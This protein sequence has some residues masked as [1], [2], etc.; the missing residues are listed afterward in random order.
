MPELAVSV[1]NQ[2]SGQTTEPTTFSTQRAISSFTADVTISEE[3]VDELTITDHPVEEGAMISDH[4]FKNP[5]RVVITVGYSGSTNGKGDGYV[6]SN[7]RT[8]S[9]SRPRANHSRSPRASVSM[10]T[11]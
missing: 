10:K 11:C 7:T 2:V 1:Q 8:S 6:P 9:S 3:H 5:M 4:A